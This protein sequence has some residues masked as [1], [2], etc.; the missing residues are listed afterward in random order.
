MR[1]FCIDCELFNDIEK[2]EQEVEPF[3]EA[4]VCFKPRKTQNEG[5]E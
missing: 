5:N 4:C 1:A 3:D 2:C